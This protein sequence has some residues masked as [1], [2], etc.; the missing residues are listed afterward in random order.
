[1]DDENEIE[2]AA[3]ALVDAVPAPA[4]V[5]HLDPYPD[6]VLSDDH[7]FVV[8][9][10]TL[11]SR[12]HEMARLDSLL[13]RIR[14]SADVFVADAEEAAR[15]HAVGSILHEATTKGRVVAES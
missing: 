10:P 1:M 13:G 4:R 14:I 15:R 6:D 11:E 9:V 5:I 3:R 2:R 7:R 12:F 8:I